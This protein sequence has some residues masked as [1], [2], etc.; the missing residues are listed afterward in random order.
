MGWR[1]GGDGEDDEDIVIDFGGSDFGFQPC[2]AGATI[3]NQSMTLFTLR[4]S[5]EVYLEGIHYKLHY[6]HR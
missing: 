6:K 2:Q 1:G 5:D 3:F 4:T